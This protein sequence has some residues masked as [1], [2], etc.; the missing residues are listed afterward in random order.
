MTTQVVNV[1][2][3]LKHLVLLILSLFDSPQHE[4]G[5]KKEVK[6]DPQN[7][8]YL[9]KESPKRRISELVISGDDE[10]VTQLGMFTGLLFELNF[11]FSQAIYHNNNIY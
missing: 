4:R 2:N 5:K 9:T 10:E 6:G 3:G 1:R 8:Q 11:F 7:F